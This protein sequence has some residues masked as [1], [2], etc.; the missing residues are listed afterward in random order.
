MT[1]TPNILIF[2][3][4][5]C[6]WD[7]FTV[8]LVIVNSLIHKVLIHKEL[9]LGKSCFC[10]LLPSN[11]FENTMVTAYCL[12]DRSKVFISYVYILKF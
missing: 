5:L 11:R 12:N 9:R 4:S 8:L 10:L 2:L 6:F 3:I 7:S 1:N